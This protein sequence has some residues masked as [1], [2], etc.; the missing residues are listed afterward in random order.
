MLS[1]KSQVTKGDRY[2]GNTQ[3]GRNV[4]QPYGGSVPE[5]GGMQ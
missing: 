1:G 4:L 2:V 5:F 3:Q